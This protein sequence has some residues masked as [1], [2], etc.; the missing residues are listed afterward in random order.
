MGFGFDCNDGWFYILW[1]LSARLEALKACAEQVKEKYGTL[2]FYFTCPAAAYDEAE[3]AVDFAELESAYTCEVCGR[4][5]RLNKGPW[6]VV[7]C[8]MCEEK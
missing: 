1:R 3:A 4:P 2:R 8:A 6:F 5:G 7:R